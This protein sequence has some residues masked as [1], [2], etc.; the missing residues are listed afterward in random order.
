LEATWIEVEGKWLVKVDVD[1]KIIEDKADVVINASGV[2][3]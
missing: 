1:G 2:L 3:K